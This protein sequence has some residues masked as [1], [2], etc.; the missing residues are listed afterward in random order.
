MSD[1]DLRRVAIHQPRFR[2]GKKVPRDHTT[3]GITVT[4]PLDAASRQAIRARWAKATPGPWMT[5]RHSRYLWIAD[6]MHGQID[7]GTIELADDREAIA[8]APSDIAALSGLVEEL[9]LRLAEALDL[10]SAL[11]HPSSSAFAQGHILLR[12]LGKEP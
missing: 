9:R 3:G 8:H 1:K 4:E 11:G 5:S 12:R 6:E 7:L 10:L 2:E